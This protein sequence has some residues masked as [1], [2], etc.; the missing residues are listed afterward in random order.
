MQR[1]AQPSCQECVLFQLKREETRGTMAG[2]ASSQL[3]WMLY[4]QSLADVHLNA[5]A[6][7]YRI[8]AQSVLMLRTECDDSLGEKA[9]GIVS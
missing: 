2:L 5:K 9:S 8:K 1:I 3:D 4:C 6:Q 7:D